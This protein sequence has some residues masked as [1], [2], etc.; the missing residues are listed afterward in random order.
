MS[1]LITTEHDKALRIVS[2]KQQVCC[3]SMRLNPH[4]EEGLSDRACKFNSCKSLLIKDYKSE[5]I[6]N[7]RK[8]EQ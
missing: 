7:D 4:Q 3:F 2:L 5:K 8:T 6:R 1:T